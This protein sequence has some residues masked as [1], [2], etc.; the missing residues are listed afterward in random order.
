M[1]LALV[2]C[3]AL[4]I[5][6]VQAQH[7]EMA[8]VKGGSYIPLYSGGE[9]DDVRINS[10]YMDITPVTHSEY[11]AFVKKFPEWRRSKVLPL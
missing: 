7:P 8:L 1:K 5:N 3:L 6:A 9:E 4:G 11:L 10:F 2:I